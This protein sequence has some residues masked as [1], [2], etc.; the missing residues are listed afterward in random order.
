MPS[1]AATQPSDFPGLHN[2]VAYAPDILSGAVPEGDEGFNTLK[3]LGIKT[4]I[5]VD[6]AASQIAFTRH[7]GMRY[8]H[9]PVSYG[10]FTDEQRLQLARAIKELPRPIYIHCHHGKHR[11]AAVAGAALVTLGDMTADEAV[12]RLKV[13]GTSP[14]YTGLYECVNLASLASNTE[15]SRASDDY[16]EIFKTSGMVQ[17]MVVI[18]EAT[19]HLKQIEK[20]G[21]Q[22]PKDHPDLVPAAE[23]GRLADTLR[24]LDQEYE[25]TL[26][27]PEFAQWMRTDAANASTLEEQLLAGTFSA[28]ELSAS[29]ARVTRSC[30]SC[31]TKYRD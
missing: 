15:L 3:A 14:S 26:Y 24:L 21:W 28:A 13:S 6:G 19:D 5:N 29:F 31:H 2:V 25:T 12:A 18:D 4:I 9:L 1:V 20:A 30:V 22:T 17:A 7:R 23:A 27:P 11:S 10:G 16:P 8:V